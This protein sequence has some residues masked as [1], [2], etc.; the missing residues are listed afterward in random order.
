MN[1]RIVSS[2]TRIIDN[3]FTFGDISND[4][5]IPSSREISV[6]ENSFMKNRIAILLL[7]FA[8]CKTITTGPQIPG[9]PPPPNFYMNQNYPNPFTSTTSIEYGV[10]S[11]GGSS[12]Y[13]SMVVYDRFQQ[14]IRTLVENASHPSGSQFIV[15]WDGLDSRGSTILPGVYIVEMRGYTPQAS[16]I[17]ITALKK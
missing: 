10:P 13:V 7:V 16:I 1:E 14:P 11:T 6:I 3:G 12:S 5:E 9:G 8:A 4:I 15:A 17:R 2:I